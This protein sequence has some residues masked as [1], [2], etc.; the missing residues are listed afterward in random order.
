[1][2]DNIGTSFS[3]KV[4]KLASALFHPLI[5]PTYGFIFLTIFSSKLLFVRNILADIELIFVFFVLS[6]IVPAFA[7]YAYCVGK[8]IENLSL[9]EREDRKTPY[10]IVMFTS[11][12]LLY[13]FG[14]MI[15]KI[16]L[17]QMLSVYLFCVIEA[18]IVNRFTKISAHA[19]SCGAMTSFIFMIN[20]YTNSKYI[21]LFIFSILISG[22]VCSSRLKLNMHNNFQIVLG[23]ILG[24]CTTFAVFF[25]GLF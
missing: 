2:Q 22:L 19:M 14:G 15:D 25:T 11:L 20:I 7:I 21:W 16:F 18:S 1:M 9:I 6:F 24:I 12:A 13:F 23:Y 8:K 5:M 3:Y 17:L 10:M 4:A